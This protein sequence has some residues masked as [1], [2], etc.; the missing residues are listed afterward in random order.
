MECL[1]VRKTGLVNTQD[2][3]AKLEESKVL[4]N[5]TGS[6]EE[7]AN[8]INNIGKNVIVSNSYYEE[9]WEKLIK[10]CNRYWPKHIAKMRSTYFSSPWSIIALVAGIILFV[11]QTL[12]TIFKS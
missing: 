2:D 3:V 7:V 6:N 4:V 5:I 12:Q 10:Y 1:S 8:M 11:L 9:E